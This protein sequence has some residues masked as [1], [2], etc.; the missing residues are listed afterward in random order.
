MIG[1]NKQWTQDECKALVLNIANRY[2]L[3]DLKFCV[4]E[5][6]I[7]GT[8]AVRMLRSTGE[9]TSRRLSLAKWLFTDEYKGRGRKIICPEPVRPVDR[10]LVTLHECAHMIIFVTNIDA[11]KKEGHGILFHRVERQ[12]DK[13]FGFAPVYNRTP[14][15]ASHYVDLNDGSKIDLLKQNARRACFDGRED[16]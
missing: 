16:Y 14:G 2:G 15:Y 8:F 1:K 4:A 12:L 5:R 10:L 3:T 11:F 13:E 9:V 7:P 6:R